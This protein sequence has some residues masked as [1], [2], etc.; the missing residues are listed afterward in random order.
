MEI[1]VFSMI[2]DGEAGY[3]SEAPMTV[4][5][6]TVM[7]KIANKGL[8]PI[9][10]GVGAQKRRERKEKEKKGIRKKC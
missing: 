10:L 2:E 8:P 1:E 5:H 7:R 9:L 3:Q 6:G 4:D